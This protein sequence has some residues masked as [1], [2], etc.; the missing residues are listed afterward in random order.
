MSF[1]S[2]LEQNG[3]SRSSFFSSGKKF[4]N[5]VVQRQR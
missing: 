1:G 2:A 4:K 5:L 3:L